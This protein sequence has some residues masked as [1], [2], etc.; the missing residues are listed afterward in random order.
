MTTLWFGL[1][2]SF[3][4]LVC[5]KCQN[6]MLDDLDFSLHLSFFLRLVRLHSTQTEKHDWAFWTQISIIIQQITGSLSL[7]ISVVSEINES[8]E[9]KKGKKKRL[10]KAATHPSWNKWPAGSISALEDER[11]F[12]EMANMS[13]RWH[14]GVTV[15]KGENGLL[16]GGY[17]IVLKLYFY[18]GSALGATFLPHSP[19]C[20]NVVA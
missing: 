3:S 11:A 20:R 19:L 10:W 15:I 7:C 2:K 4:R 8:Q 5:M 17:Y 14:I 6:M 1:L 9:V 18:Y 12:L 16:G 13:L